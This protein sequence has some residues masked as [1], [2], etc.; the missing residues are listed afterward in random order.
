MLQV[1]GG[2]NDRTLP[3]TMGYSRGGFRL[4]EKKK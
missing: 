2:V 4:G 3:W 1:M